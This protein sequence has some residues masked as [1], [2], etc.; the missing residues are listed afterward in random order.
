MACQSGSSGQMASA[1]SSASAATSGWFRV[2]IALRACRTG[3]SGWSSSSFPAIIADT[4]GSICRFWIACW[5]LTSGS[6]LKPERMSAMDFSSTN[7]ERTWAACFPLVTNLCRSF[8]SAQCP[9]LRA[10]LIF[11]VGRSSDG[12]MARPAIEICSSI[13]SKLECSGSKSEGACVRMCRKCALFVCLTLS[14]RYSAS[15]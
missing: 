1:V 13:T 9:F 15:N 8:S 12:E 5:K 11:R 4:F 10:W 7:T 3:F 14:V 6:L 2:A